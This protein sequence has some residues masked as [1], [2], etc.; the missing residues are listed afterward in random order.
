MQKHKNTTNIFFSKQKKSNENE[1]KSNLH[2][3]NQKK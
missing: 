1:T 3:I 2:K